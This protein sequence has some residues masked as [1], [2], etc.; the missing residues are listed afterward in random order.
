MA[1]KFDVVVIGAGP[2]G[3]VAAGRLHDGGLRTAIVERELVGGECAYWACIPSKTLLRP[4]EVRAEAERAPGLCGPDYRWEEVVEYR[5]YMIRDLDDSKQV[6]EYKRDGLEVFKGDGVIRGPGQVEAGDQLLQTERIIIATG[7]ETRVPQVEGLESAGYWTNREATTLRQVPDRVIILGGGPV[8]IELG[9]LMRRFGASVHLIE[10]ADQ[11]LSREDPRIS[12]LLL[13]A[14]RGEQVEVSLGAEVS[15]VST[16][17]G[18]RVV[19]LADGTTIEAE[20]LVVATGRAPRVLG[21]GLETVGFD[22]TPKG[23]EVDECCRVTEGIWAVGDVTGVMPFTHVAKYQAQIAVAD[24]AGKAVRAD[25]S[26]VPRAVF[27]DPEIAAVG[28]TEAQA[29]Q[30]GIDVESVRLELASAIARPWTY[31][32]DPRGELTLVADRRQEILVGAWAVAPMASEW[33]HYA[34]L[35]IKAKIPLSVLRDSPPQFPTYTEAYVKALARLE[36]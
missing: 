35:A 6:E 30:Q 28:L 12:E 27:C 23:I 19:E 33:I 20:E 25:Y 16:S 2:A 34:A 18:G 13:E 9:Q 10:A 4:P 14:L 1:D 11:L 32:R 17:D 22:P 5:D 24:I 3:E 36:L 8:G 7:S 29:R 26:A 21:I 31:E 15:R